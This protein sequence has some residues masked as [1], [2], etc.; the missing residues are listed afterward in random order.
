MTHLSSP[1]GWLEV[2]QTATRMPGLTVPS[3]APSAPCMTEQS[4]QVCAVPV[5]GYTRA[6]V[7]QSKC[8]EKGW[9]RNA[10]IQRDGCEFPYGTAD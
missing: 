10:S 2:V 7:S 3:A 8:R 4:A 6:D 9:K 1:W 5:K